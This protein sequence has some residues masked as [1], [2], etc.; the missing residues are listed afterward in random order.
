MRLST[1]Y[2]CNIKLSI[3][4]KIN[5]MKKITFL[6][7]LIVMAIVTAN[8]AKLQRY[9]TVTGAGAKDGTSWANAASDITQVISDLAWDASWV[10]ADGA[11]IFVGAGQYD[12]P[13]NGFVMVDKINVYGGYPAAGGALRNVL[14]N[15]TILDG[16]KN[17]TR[18][19]LQKEADPAFTDYCVWDG[20]IL[21][22]GKAGNGAGALLT[23]KGVLSNCVIRNC[24]ATGSY[25]I[26]SAVQGKKNLSAGA[27]GTSATLYNCLIINNIA[28]KAT[29][30]FNTAPGYM[31]YCTIA[32]N[33]T[34]GIINVNAQGVGTDVSTS[35]LACAGILLDNWTHWSIGY[36]SIV[37]GNEGQT[38]A[39]LVS[40]NGGIKNFTTCA[41]QGGA[42][43]I[44]AT[45]VNTPGLITT[46][47]LFVKPTSFTGL[48][49]T[50]EK[51][52][53]LVASDF[54]IKS[55][56]PGIGVATVTGLPNTFPLLPTVDLAGKTLVVN[57]K[58]D[59]GAF[60]STSTE[61]LAP[62]QTL[63]GVSAAV[64]DELCLVSGLQSN[65]KVNIFN[66]NG[67]QLYS[68]VAV[69]ETMFINA[70]SFDKGVVL[71]NVSRGASTYSQKVVNK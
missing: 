37:W 69:V 63:T 21:Q 39:Q 17:A 16:K 61:I 50:D 71:I 42:V 19:I 20:F 70:S 51:W 5:F 13:S 15:Q 30:N 24:N 38:T 53:E 58:A 44:T 8:A 9:I 64:I 2:I 18:L 25:A 1:H 26:G 34:T 32:N 60:Q 49:D 31:I 27:A 28:G 40:Q 36:N 10:P 55:N 67:K 57:G 29:V 3:T 41:I 11:D 14:S 68:G 4:L 52:A 46:D 12:A 43:D 54:H 66:V 33:K 48:A 6:I 22:N 56:S 47:P 65:D 59:I 45:A 7:A 23:L 35:G 62:K